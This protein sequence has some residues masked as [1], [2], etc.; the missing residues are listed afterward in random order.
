MSNRPWRAIWKIDVDSCFHEV[1]CRVGNLHFQVT[2]HNSRAGVT[3]RIYI[4]P[5]SAMNWVAVSF[6]ALALRW[7][8][9]LGVPRRPINPFG[10]MVYLTGLMVFYSE[11]NADSI[12]AGVAMSRSEE[13]GFIDLT[14]QF[15]DMVGEDISFYYQ[16]VVPAL[17]LQNAL[18][19]EDS[20][21]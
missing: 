20:P 14:F 5:I 11:Q 3:D 4:G 10:G 17:L 13:A 16:Y 1:L 2:S 21:E 8:S 15:Y 12:R 6:M 9:G 18:L 7:A 19:R